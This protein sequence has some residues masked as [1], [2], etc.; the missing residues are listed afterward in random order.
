MNPWARTVRN[1]K[2]VA[3]PLALFALVSLTAFVLTFVSMGQM[4]PQV[5]RNLSD[6][7]QARYAAD[8]GVE[9]A[10]DQLAN[11]PGAG[12]GS[13][14]SL[15]QGP[16]VAGSNPPAV[17]LIGP[18]PL[19]L[20]GL[21]QAFG[22]YTV[23]VRNDS[24][25]T[26]QALTGTAPEVGVA[27]ADNN[28]TVIVTATGTY[29]GVT[30]TIQVVLRR[31]TLPPF[32]GAYSMPGVQADIMAT[33]NSNFSIDGRDYMCTANC[34]DPDF[35]KRTYALNANQANKKY[36]IAVS[37]TADASTM[38]APGIAPPPPGSTPGTQWNSNP[39]VSY[40]TVIENDLNNSQELNVIGKDQTNPGGA[41]VKGVNTIAPTG[42][43]D[44]VDPVVMQNFL[45]QLAS[46]S[47]T[48][49][50]QS[51][52]ACPMVLTGNSS[53]AYTSKPT[54]TNGC[55]VNQTLD[56][57]TRQDPKLV[58]FRG[59]LDPSSSF[60]GLRMLNNIQGAG[61]LVVEDGDLRTL[62]NLTWDGI[63][64]VTGR[65]VST[66]FD[67]GSNVN[68]TGVT[69]SNETVWNEGGNQNQ[70]PYYDGYFG[71]NMTTLRYSKESVDSMQ[72]KLLFRMSTWREL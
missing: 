66:I 10:F 59:E 40:E 15:L 18:A 68:V 23:Q 55:G 67:A 30:R 26:D 6:S 7:S 60:T 17:W 57:G 24:V 28:G 71:G 62:G 53:G 58:Y 56:L 16:A 38:P 41:A 63:V 13:W 45:N 54:L 44:K 34:S 69:V 49:V 72:R 48:T 4:E 70:N 9:A 37:G 47:G 14:T 42:A 39:Q 20:P 64:I 50:L 8:S 3:L 32:Q 35:A 65:Y 46:F 19:P 11:A 33:S 1:E 27:N 22:T 12:A 25:A 51:K 29:R 31:V 21:T 36:G 52:I 43:A 61:I 2:G 5:S